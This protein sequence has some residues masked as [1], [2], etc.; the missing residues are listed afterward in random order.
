M[1]KHFI[2]TLSNEFFE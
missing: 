1:Q 2:F